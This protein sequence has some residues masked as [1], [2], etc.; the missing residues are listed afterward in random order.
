L[1]PSRDGENMRRDIEEPIRTCWRRISGQKSE[2]IVTIFI[3]ISLMKWLIEVVMWLLFVFFF[4]ENKSFGAFQYAS[5]Y[6]IY[7][8]LFSLRHLDEPSGEE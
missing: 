4:Q 6:H 8:N 1:E 2:K 7:Y 5:W 3:R